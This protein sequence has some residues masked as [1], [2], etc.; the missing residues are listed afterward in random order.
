MSVS[1][2][3]LPYSEPRLYQSLKLA[4]SNHDLV[5]QAEMAAFSDLPVEIRAVMYEMA[6]RRTRLRLELIPT[7]KKSFFAPQL[8]FVSKRYHSEIKSALVKH[9]THVVSNG[10]QLHSLPAI[11]GIHKLEIH[12]PVKL[13]TAN[14]INRAVAR[15]PKLSEVIIFTRSQ[16]KTLPDLENLS[17]V[18]ALDS[19]RIQAASIV[20]SAFSGTPKVDIWSVQHLLP[21]QQTWLDHIFINGGVECRGKR[22][23]TTIEVEQEFYSGLPK[24][25]VQVGT[26]FRRGA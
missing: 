18:D 21:D 6:F 7:Y 1:L 19:D 23:S 12:F 14:D 2:S 5:A 25:G 20:H 10:W 22:I 13:T 26:D 9:A 4:F 3:A 8:L 15:H 24:E 17:H 11:E 16:T